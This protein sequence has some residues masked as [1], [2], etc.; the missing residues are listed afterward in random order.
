MRT[1]LNMKCLSGGW[2][3]DARNFCKKCG[4]ELSAVPTCPCGEKLFLKFIVHDVQ[5]GE[6]T[7]CE[8]CGKEWTTERIGKVLSNT[9]QGFLN[10]LKEG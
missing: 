3:D 2:E 6:K 7:F 5:D 9:L 1:C 8:G 4:E 10:T